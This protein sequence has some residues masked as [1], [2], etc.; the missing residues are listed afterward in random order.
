MSIDRDTTEK[1]VFGE[2]I[3]ECASTKAWKM[4]Y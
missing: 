4:L 1:T 3:D 2:S